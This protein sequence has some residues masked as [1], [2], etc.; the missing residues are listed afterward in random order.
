MIHLIAPVLL[1]YPRA[2][3]WVITM[4][5]Q[6]FE[7]GQ[8]HR[9]RLELVLDPLAVQN[10]DN[11]LYIFQGPS[12]YDVKKRFYLILFKNLTLKHELT[13]TIFHGR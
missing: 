3:I 1:I 2:I 8:L 13:Q 11:Q 4:V 9:Q 12:Y 10:L 5:F 7:F 6:C